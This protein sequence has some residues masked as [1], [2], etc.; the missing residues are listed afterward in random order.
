MNET[1]QNAAL[2]IRALSPDESRSKSLRYLLQSTARLLS[3][4][5][6][7]DDEKARSTLKDFCDELELDAVDDSWRISFRGQQTLTSRRD[8]KFYTVRRAGELE[9]Q[10][11]SDQSQR[12]GELARG[13][14]LQ[15]CG[16]SDKG[17]LP[18]SPRR[19][20]ETISTFLLVVALVG[21]AFFPQ[22][23]AGL[24]ALGAYLFA[25]NSRF[26][27][28]WIVAGSL[29][30]LVFVSSGSLSGWGGGSHA[31]SFVL[32]STALVILGDQTNDWEESLRRR[33]TPG[34]ILLVAGPPVLLGLAAFQTESCPILGLLALLFVLVAV[35]S[36]CLKRHPILRALVPGL[37]LLLASTLFL[38]FT[39]SPLFANVAV[40]SL[41]LLVLLGATLSLTFVTSVVLLWGSFRPGARVSL[42]L[43]FPLVFLGGAPLWP[44]FAWSA[45]AGILT[46]A[47]LVAL[48]QSWSWARRRLWLTGR[49]GA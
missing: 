2:P 42:L 19:T 34:Q 44:S 46:F 40:S 48:G 30:A 49:S 33:D 32:L 43:G 7:R 37:G 28:A 45:A 23:F 6:Y 4:N 26:R 20:S 41:N 9:D 47:S 15:L 10:L 5:T 16:F 21:L 3:V 13:I 35:S 24:L 22:G 11:A 14:V 12:N 38:F 17:P 39:G 18:S 36:R 8:F 31:T 1:G 29:S 27:A 25:G